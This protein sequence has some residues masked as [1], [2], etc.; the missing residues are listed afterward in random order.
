MKHTQLSAYSF[1]FL[2]LAAILFCSCGK[3]EAG[4]FLN[5]DKLSPNSSDFHYDFTIVHMSKCILNVHRNSV[6]FD[7]YTDEP[8]DQYEIFLTIS[9]KDNPRNHNTYNLGSP[10]QGVVSSTIE[11]LSA[12]TAYIYTIEAST[13]ATKKE[14]CSSQFTTTN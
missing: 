6:E 1:L 4:R 5:P 14:L 2:C 3:E 10:V 7:I 13:H 8:S 9:Q 12:Q 11:Q